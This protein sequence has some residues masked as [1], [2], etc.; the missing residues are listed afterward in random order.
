MNIG[1]EM[2]SDAPNT[3]PPVH[4][5]FQIPFLAFYFTLLAFQISSLAFQILLLTFEIPW[6]AF[7]ILLLAF[8]IR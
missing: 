3:Y 2:D 7:Q 6:V 5:C 1:L 8:Q 4:L